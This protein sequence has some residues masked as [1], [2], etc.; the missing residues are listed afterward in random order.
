MKFKVE[1][2]NSYWWFWVITL[3]F[4]VAAIAGWIPGYYCVIAISAIQVLVFA[5]VRQSL[6]AYPTQIRI[7]YFLLTLFGVWP[8]VRQPFY[9]LMLIATIMVTF[10][11]MCSIS[12]MLKRMPWNRNH[13]ISLY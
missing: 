5:V 1:P 3:V 11:G 2:N 10:F 8:A 12:L 13:S 9:V 4:M 6:T 7:V